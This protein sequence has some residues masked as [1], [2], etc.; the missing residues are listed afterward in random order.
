[1]TLTA[2]PGGARL[3]ALLADVRDS[4]R[5]FVATLDGLGDP[6][7]RGASALPGWN[8]AQ[9]VTHVARSADAY[10][11]LLTSARTG[12]EPGPRADAAA[13][14]RALREGAGRGA[15]ELV[16]DLRC[17]LDRFLDEAAS[18]PAERWPTPVTAL[19][20][21]RHPAWF[22]LHRARR[23]LE[24]HHVDLNLGHGTADW[25]ADYVAWAL[26]ATAATLAARGFPVARLAA[27]DLGRAWPLGPTGPAVTA[28]G[29]VLL[30][31]LAGRG[32]APAA[33]PDHPLPT[34]PVW[35]LPPVPGWG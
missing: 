33:D 6:Q 13:L 14:D 15:A 32:P 7:A 30:A 8:R 5:R 31:W 4:A 22:T 23:E 21:W 9:V 1:M 11:W 16:D 35:P 10:R 34:P 29:H 19:A 2:D 27:T 20:G 26:D 24:T 28:P 17:S 3:A 12:A 18:M 25:P